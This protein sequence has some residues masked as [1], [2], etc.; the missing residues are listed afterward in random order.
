MS[1]KVF[2]NKSMGLPDAQIALDPLDS[3]LS[4]IQLAVAPPHDAIVPGG[5]EHPGG[6]SFA[7]SMPTQTSSEAQVWPISR[8]G[9][10]AHAP[11]RQKPRRNKKQFEFALMILAMTILTASTVVCVS[12]GR[13]VER[14]TYGAGIVAGPTYA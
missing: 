12:S 1:E 6:V 8:G 2:G 3:P 10:E 4:A 11:R 14:Q 13:V 7:L 5:P 9:K